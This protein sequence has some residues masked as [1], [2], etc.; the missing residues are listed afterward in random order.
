L[1]ELS[2]V[3][4]KMENIKNNEKQN[5]FNM[6][7][8]FIGMLLIFTLLTNAYSVDQN[9]LIEW[10]M[11]DGVGNVVTDLRGPPHSN[12]VLV[13]GA[14][15]ENTDVA[16]GTYDVDFDGNGDI[17][18]VG[19][20]NPAYGVTPENKF[21]SSV[22]FW[23]RP[24]TNN[25]DKLFTFFGNDGTSVFEFNYDTNTP[26][27]RVF[28]YK[29]SFG[30]MQ[31][32]VLTGLP[33]ISTDTYHHIAFNV[34]PFAEQI[35]VF[36]DGVDY[37][38][39]PIPNVPPFEENY[40]VRLGTSQTL[41]LDYTGDMD[42]FFFNDF[43]MNQS[44]V[45][46][47]YTTNTITLQ[48][49]PVDDPVEEVQPEDILVSYSPAENESLYNPIVF[50]ATLTRQADCDV[51]L[52]KKLHKEFF[53][54]IS[55]SFEEYLEINDH[56]WQIYCSY[57]E[58]NTQYFQLSN[59]TS[60]EVLGDEPTQVRFNIIGT[61]FD[62]SK[63]DLF[64]TSPCLN[65][66][67]SAI[68]IDDMKPY[69][70]EYNPEGA[71]FSE[72][73]NGV[74]ILNVS[75]GIN[76]FCLH[77][78][79]IVVNGEGKTNNYDIVESLGQLDLGKVDVPKQNA[80]YTIKLEAFDIYEVYDPKAYN[81]S[82]SGLMGGLVLVLFGAFICIMGVRANNGKIVVAGALIFMAGFGVSMNGILGVLL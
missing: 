54:V 68:G 34:D 62:V 2:E 16:F 77:N 60:F 82:W 81:K 19:V 78:G 27:G 15:F 80:V 37:G 8:F 55:F 64:V 56:S 7:K 32:V 57:I 66:G 21:Y 38:V 13:G 79:R 12:G 53:D 28:I 52:D 1:L 67:Y 49:D 36:F 43:L 11:E 58:N 73:K 35:R 23:F 74:A 24:A 69:R 6:N 20:N 33:S 25:Q 3:K 26:S 70:A 9:V 41:G 51:Y 22:A 30:I 47:L 50:E 75:S 14:N 5:R 42:A 40:I 17:I 76:E 65:K 4:D 59:Y 46:E 31:N 44:Q 29:D 48:K 39:F 45:T 61:D 63:T 10:Q 72:V 18:Q 71:Y